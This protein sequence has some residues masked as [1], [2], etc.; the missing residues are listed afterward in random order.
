[1]T[2]N[3]PFKCELQSHHSDDVIQAPEGGYPTPDFLTRIL[4][5]DAIADTV[6]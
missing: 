6:C 4:P 1:M 2:K 5:S 3:G